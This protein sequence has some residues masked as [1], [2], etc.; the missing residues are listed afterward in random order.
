MK[1]KRNVINLFALLFTIVL[2]SCSA[3]SVEDSITT[4]ETQKNYSHSNEELEVLDLINTYRV[5]Q[6]LTPL[7]IIEHISYKSN[8]HNNYMV[9]VNA[10]NH[11]G[12]EQRKV[13]FENVLGA[14][15]VGENVAFGYSSPQ[16]VV[17]AWIASSGH[18]SNIEGDYTHFGI[19][20]T[21]DAEGQKYYT[22]MFIKK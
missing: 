14:Y 7:S 13:N 12:F 2:T 11:D 17:N 19:S 10:V 16:S 21:L 4:T 18:L 22:N 6:G 15:R 1:M 8:E 5:N 9:S 3:E 20:I